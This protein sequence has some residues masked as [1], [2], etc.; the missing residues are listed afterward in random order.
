MYANGKSIVVRSLSDPTNIR[1]YTDHQYQTTCAQIS[2]NGEWVASGDV[3]GVVRVWGL[4]DDYTLKAEHRPLSGS[5]DD[6]QWSDDC[7]RIVACGDGKGG[8]FAKAFLW[9]SGSSVGDVSGMTKRV[10]SIAIKP[11]RPFRVVTASEDFSVTMFTGPPFKFDGVKYKHGNFA[12]CV[13]YNLN[14]SLFASCGSDGIGIIYDGKFGLPVAGLAPGGK[15]VA[16]DTEGHNGTVYAL[17]WSPDGKTLLTVGAD[18]TAKLWDVSSVQP[19]PS[20]TEAPVSPDPLPP[21]PVTKTLKPWSDSKKATLSDMQVGCVFVGEVPVTLSLDGTL[22]VLSTA[23]DGEIV[24]LPG[25]GKPI[26]CM[27]K[28]GNDSILTVGLAAVNLP[29]SCPS[30]GYAWGTENNSQT[31]STYKVD[32]KHAG[33]VVAAASTS[34]GDTVFTVGLDDFCMSISKQSTDYSSK[35]VA[36]LPGQPSCVACD[37][38]GEVVVVGCRESVCVFAGDETNNESPVTVKFPEMKNQAI[39]AA[40]VSSDGAVLVVGFQNGDVRLLDVQ[41]NGPAVAKLIRSD[42]LPIQHHRAEVTC[43]AFHPTDSNVVA[44]SDL[45]RKLFVWRVDTQQ[46]LDEKHAKLTFHN[47]RVTSLSWSSGGGLLAS[48]SLDG[49]VIVWDPVGNGAER[50]TL[51]NAHQ[52]GVTSLQWIEKVLASGGFDACVRTWAVGS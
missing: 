7:Q 36:K 33:A 25:H 14:G 50:K 13:R 41:K 20:D 11:T 51:K 23:G 39:T 44:T 31:K 27:A 28:L 37:K 47:A 12:N 18:K 21:V 46:L 4:N 30:V 5:V 29:T 3:S 35:T 43:V 32:L 24:S 49:S 52:G 40:G 42:C 1:L 10:N 17:S 48:G 16:K 19:L 6:L 2:P 45:N 38:N 8:A 26:A 34:N 15:R 9:D 22:N